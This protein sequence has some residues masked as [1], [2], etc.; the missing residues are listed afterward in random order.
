MDYLKLF[1]THEEYEDFVSGGTMVKP[2]V[3]HCVQD[4]EVHY[5]PIKTMADEYLTFVAKENGTFTFTPQNNNVISYS[6]NGGETWTN[7]N[8]V[9]VSSDDK[10][11]WKGELNSIYDDQSYEGNGIGTFSSSGRFDAQGNIMSL[12][13][14]DDFKN[15]KSLSGK[16]GA[17]VSLFNGA[18][19][20]NAN[21]LI[22]PATTLSY[23]CYYKMFH[24]CQN[25]ISAPKLPATTL[26][27]RCYVAMF[28][29]CTSLTTAPELPATTLT[30]GCYYNMFGYCT[31][32]TS[33]PILSATT[34]TQY[35]YGDMFN[36]CTSLTTAPELPA[37]TL[38]SNCYESMFTNC[39]SLTTAPELPATTLVHSCYE[40]MFTNCTSLTTAPELPATTLADSCYLYMFSD[41]TSLTTAPVLSATTLVHSCYEY[42]FTNCT[43]LTNV[44]TVPNSVKPVSSEYCCGMYVDC[45]VTLSSDYDSSAYEGCDSG[46]GGPEPD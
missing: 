5:N 12:L 14:G 45:N 28:Y 36:G 35:C 8:S 41:C 19:I 26:E 24:Y 23:E 15:K 33:A 44:A 11:M 10:V 37:T 40:Y 25:L 42:M 29:G 3:S 2:N 22:L 17:F 13:Y 43:S 6:T 20:V 39:E 46:G 34:L 21:N 4:N 27:E 7:G 32:L 38:A 9:Q 31:N 1:Q 30:V 16:G 18:K